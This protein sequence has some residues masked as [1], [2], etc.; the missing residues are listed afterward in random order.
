MAS[1]VKLSKGKQPPRA[2]DFTDHSDQDDAGQ[3]RRKRIR[4]GIVTHDE[5]RE[6]KGRIEKLL[7]AQTLNQTPDGETLRWLSGVSDTI[8]KRIAKTGL[9]ELREPQAVAPA[10]GAFLESYIDGRAKLKPNTRRNYEVTR[11]HLLGYFGA[12]RKLTDIAPGDADAWRESL[13]AKGL[14]SATVSREVKRAQQFFRAALRQ[15]IIDENPFTDLATPA[16]V[17]TSRQ[18]FVTREESQK[19]LDACPDA[20]WRLIFALSRY[21]GLRCPSEHLSLTWGDVD[22]EHG[23]MTVRSPKTEHHPGGDCRVIPIF[24][25]LL[26]HLEAVWEETDP[27]VES[28]ITRYRQKN[29]NLR[30]QL[31]RIM[32]QAGVK[33]WPKLFHNL[34]ASRETELCESFPLHVVCAW[35]GNSAV[36]AAKHYLQVT[37]DHFESA[38]EAQQEAQ[39]QDRAQVGTASQAQKKTPRGNGVMR[40]NATPYVSVQ[41]NT[42]PRRGVEP[43]SP[44]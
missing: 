17:N 30:T 26:L 1:V 33:P 39:M 34:R 4:L 14:S 11:G 6:A 29:V 2:I 35:I 19:V 5:A 9:C 42:V 13:I 44:P 28:V 36:I 23:R 38:A 32:A 31:L 24:P 25:E 10:L 20:Q 16:Q 15:R 21:G 27:G 8:L 22:W 7:T 37:D 3:P 43:L 41:A 40:N 12:D 18:Y